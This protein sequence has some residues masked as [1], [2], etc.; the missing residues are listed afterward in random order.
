[1]Q[2]HQVAEKCIYFGLSDKVGHQAAV[3]G[4]I[5]RLKKTFLKLSKEGIFPLL[6]HIFSLFTEKSST[7]T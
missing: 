7:L 4:A 2:R 1:M 5:M 3:V 6:I